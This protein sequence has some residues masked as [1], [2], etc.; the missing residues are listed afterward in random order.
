MDNLLGEHICKVDAKGRLRLPAQILKQIGDEAKLG[1]VLNRGFERC[2]VLYPRSAWNRIS[3]NIRQLNQ[4]VKKNREFIRYF[5]RGATELEL[6]GN[7]RILIPKH[8]SDYA[9]L[10]KELVL[11]AYFDKIEIWSK[12]EYDRLMEDIPDEFDLLAEDVMGDIPEV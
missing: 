10:N 1:F 3:D 6:D 8:L 12:E 9:M 11:M 4:F 7:S 5:F 2:M